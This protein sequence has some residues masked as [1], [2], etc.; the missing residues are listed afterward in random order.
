MDLVV[1]LMYLGETDEFVADPELAYGD[2][3]YPPHLPSKGAAY[4]EV[5]L[6]AHRPS[7]AST[8]DLEVDERKAV[9]S[10]KKERGNFWFSRSEYSMAVQCYRKA[11]EYFDDEGIVMEVPI[12]RYSL[13]EPLQDL[14][15]EKIK[16]YNNLTYN[17][18]MFLDLQNTG[19]TKNSAKTPNTI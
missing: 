13:P 6:L 18:K 17:K 16:A 10:R 2:F 1:A 14:V 9:G 5:T 7:L 12:D 19:C 11:V 3:G 8:M 15:T 4:F